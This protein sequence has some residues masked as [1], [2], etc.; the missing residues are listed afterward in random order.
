MP[1]AGTRRCRPMQSGARVFPGLYPGHDFGVGGGCVDARPARDQQRVDRR[2][3][4][5]QLRRH[6]P[7][8]RRRGHDGCRRRDHARGIERRCPCARGDLVGRREDL[9]RPGHVEK[10][11]RGKSEDLDAARRLLAENEGSLAYPPQNATVDFSR[12]SPVRPFPHDPARH[13]LADRLAAVRGAGPDRSD[14]PVRGFP[15]ACPM[16]PIAST[17]RPRR[18][19]A[20]CGAWGSCR[21]ARW[22]TAP[23]LDLLHVPG[24]FGQETLMDDAGSFGAVDRAPGGERTLRFFGMHGRAYLRRGRAFE[25]TARHDALGVDD[26]AAVFRRDPGRRARGVRRQ[27]RLRCRESPRALTARCG[28]RPICAGSRSRRRSS[29][30]SPTRPSRRST[31]AR[32]R[33]RR[34]PCWRRC[35]KLIARSPSSASA[36]LAA[37]PGASELAATR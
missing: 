23:Q 29:S 20:T 8:P 13:S 16:R 19:R 33:L 22:A 11:H 21:T 9:Q 7:Q 27:P 2:P 14:G 3:P 6:E 1:P 28:S 31:A 30:R 24:G 10:L 35:R 25:G 12:P 18:R 32:R 5:R 26:S 37:S 15:R 34:P 36:P 4:T 17:P